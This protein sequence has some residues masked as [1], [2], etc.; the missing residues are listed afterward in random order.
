M[1][2]VNVSWVLPTTR[3]S[4]K[5]LPVNQIKHVEI[6]ISADGGQNFVKLDEYP[7]S[8]LS[9]T[10]TD[11]EPGDWFFRGFVVDTEGRISQGLTSSIKIP[12]HTAPSALLQLKL[13]L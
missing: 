3:E 13:E 5:A 11:L 12:D 8:V 4:G 9:I 1:P 6:Q 2:N 7:P 10:Q